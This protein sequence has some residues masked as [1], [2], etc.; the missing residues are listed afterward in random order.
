M[1]GSWLF[2][3]KSK[4]GDKITCFAL[5]CPSHLSGMFGSAPAWG[6][7]LRSEGLVFPRQL[8]IPEAGH[9]FGSSGARV[10]LGMTGT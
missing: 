4:V 7:A 6:W 5:P 1:I 9:Q 2:K 3:Y 8:R 10:Q